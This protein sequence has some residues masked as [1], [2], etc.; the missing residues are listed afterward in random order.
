M[1]RSLQLFAGIIGSFALSAYALV[2]LPKSQIGA[3]Q[4]Q[5][6]EDEGKITEIYPIQNR[7]IVEQGRE[8]YAS[9]GCFYCHTQQVRD[10]QNGQDLECGWGNRRTVARD[11][12]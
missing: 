11:Y 1:N 6:V 10:A 7:G 2:S 12:I 3:L 4:P 8:V 5:T 9:N